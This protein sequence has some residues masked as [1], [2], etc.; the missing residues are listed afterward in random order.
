MEIRT[1]SGIGKLPLGIDT[2]IHVGRHRLRSAWCP[3]AL[4]RLRV[5]SFISGAPLF[6]GVSIRL[7]LPIEMTCS[8]FAAACGGPVGSRWDL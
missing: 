1:A 4:G 6:F 5:R 2:E 3:Q 7:A 8:G